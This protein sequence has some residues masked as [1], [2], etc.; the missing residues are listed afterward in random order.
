MVAA[1]AAMFVV[2]VVWRFLTFTGFTNDHYAHL[3]L[4]Q[5]LL[6]GDRP[7]R[8]FSDPGWPLAYVLSAAAWQFAGSQPRGGM[9]SGRP[10]RSDLL[11]HAR[12]WRP[13]DFRDRC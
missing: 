8:D 6:L 7:I 9:G 2:T 1:A 4:A 10:R 12:W 3:A 13:T 11:R 5:Q